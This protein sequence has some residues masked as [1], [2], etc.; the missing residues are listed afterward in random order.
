MERIV[1]CALAAGLA[2]ALA[3]AEDPVPDDASS[4]SDPA[5]EVVARGE[6]PYR[7]RDIDALLLVT[8]RYLGRSIQEEESARLRRVLADILVARQR[9]LPLLAGLPEDLDPAA[10][11]QLVLDLLAYRPEPLAPAPER[12]A[13]EPAGDPPA[14]DAGDAGSGAEV[15]VPPPTEHLAQGRALAA[16]LLS[17]PD[18]GL[19]RRRDDGT[20]G[21]VTLG[22]A[23]KLAEDDDRAAVD[24]RLPVVQ[25]A[26]IQALHA[27]SAEEALDLDPD[28]IRRR[29]AN[30]LA[31]ALP[32]FE[33]EV[34]ITG[35]TLPPPREE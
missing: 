30:A 25:D 8:G 35:I 2:T 5:L 33:G 10:R 34:L 26:F 12:P 15:P 1:C 7:V 23:L 6:T 28:L 13:Q 9:L 22:L 14:E 17:L 16:D 18:M 20:T 27:L 31:E 24:A 3:A 29:L 19:T 32:G 21:R 4:A 11:E